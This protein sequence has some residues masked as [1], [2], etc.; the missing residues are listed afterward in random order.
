MIDQRVGLVPTKVSVNHVRRDGGQSF[1]EPAIMW[2]DRLHVT[3]AR[4]SD[5]SKIGFSVD[6]DLSPG[7]E[8]LIFLVSTIRDGI[9]RCD[10]GRHLVIM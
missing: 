9:S 8:C 5:A 2:R 7:G 6:L 3:K 10:V 4:N 1:E